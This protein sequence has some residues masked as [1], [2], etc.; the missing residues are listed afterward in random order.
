MDM[1]LKQIR[2]VQFRRSRRRVLLSSALSVHVG[3]RE[4]SSSE[5]VVASEDIC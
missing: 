4:E 3:L 2:H 5:H 1:A